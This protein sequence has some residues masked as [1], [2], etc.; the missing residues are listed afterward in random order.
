MEIIFKALIR[1]RITQIKKNQIRKFQPYN[2][3]LNVVD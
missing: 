3:K 1:G 2:P